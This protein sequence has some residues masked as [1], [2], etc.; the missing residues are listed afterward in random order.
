VSKVVIGEAS[1]SREVYEVS[2]FAT[3]ARELGQLLWRKARQGGEAAAEAL[4]QQA[5]LQRLAGQARKLDRDRR[6][7]FG[8]MGAKVYALHG[9]GKIRNQDV[10]EDC[11]RVDEIAA[12]IQALRQQMQDIRA[13]SLAQGVKLPELDD[14]TALTDEGTESG[15]AGVA[16][17][18]APTDV[19]PEAGAAEGESR[20]SPEPEPVP[21]GCTEKAEGDEEASSK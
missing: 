1:A 2:D 16:L 20:T 19:P 6:L 3:R 7:L 13:A 17:A 21:D 5:S 12:E 4:E 15:G 14:E 10:L 11:R 18:P 8:Q 9:Q